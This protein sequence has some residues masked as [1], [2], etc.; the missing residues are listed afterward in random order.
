MHPSK[1]G[2]RKFQQDY[3]I[4]YAYLAGA[5]YRGIASKEMLIKLAQSNLMGF[6]GTGGMD[7]DWIQKQILDIKAILTKGESFGCNLLYN[8]KDPELELETAKLYIDQAVRYISAS[9]YAQITPALVYYKV[10]GLK[11]LN[12]GE[13]ICENFMMAKLSR[14]E[15]ASLF[16]SPPP[17]RIL[18]ELFE[19]NLINSSER[20]MAKDV[21]MATDIVVEADSG[22][23]T[24]QGNLS[25]LLPTIIRMR[26]KIDISKKIRIGAAGGIGTT[27]ACASAFVLGADFVLTGSINQCTVESGAHENV[28]EMLCFAG[29]QDMAY[30]P[31]GDMF[32]LGAKVQVFKKGILFPIRAQKLYEIYQSYNAID[33]IPASTIEFLEKNIFKMSLKDVWTQTQSY[34]E[35]ESPIVLKMAFN[36]PK[37]KMASIFKWYFAKSVTY[38]MEGDLKHKIDFQIHS[39]PALG[40]F[41]EWVKASKFENWRNRHVD[42]IAEMLMTS[43]ASYLERKSSIYNN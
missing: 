32:E 30:C 10:K 12:S 34:L 38:A 29:V 13:V 16:L 9:A 6:L 41:N 43:T 17:K 7:L 37:V 1:L 11:R 20:E 3:K 18:D 27:E 5:M 35:T 24:D 14:P 33:E 39:G 23:H 8:L 2:S 31:A 21:I 36:N 22:G 26:D 42:E 40:A 28:K 4:K 19:K 25:T 15:V